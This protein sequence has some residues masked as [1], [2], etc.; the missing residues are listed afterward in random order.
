MNK[1]KDV[2]FGYLCGPVWGLGGIDP[3][4]FSIEIDKCGLI[5][6]T[7]YI[8]D[9]IE[10]DAISFQLSL[11]T[12]KKINTILDNNSTIIKKIKRNL[13]N[14]SCDGVFNQ[15]NFAGKLITAYNISFSDEESLLK[16]NPD[17]YK[18]YVKNIRQ[19]N[20][21]VN[22]FNAIANELQDELKI[23][24]IELELFVCTY[25]NVD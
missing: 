24:G 7:T 10:K 5:K 11:T 21:V 13:D 9:G 17:Y 22:I 18:I 8:F 25:F 23:K 16:Y 19:E 2:L 1:N 4:G 12:I 6:Y 15:F 14:G 3:G 20:I